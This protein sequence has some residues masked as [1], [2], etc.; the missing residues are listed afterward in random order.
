MNPLTSGECTVSPQCAKS[1]VVDTVNRRILCNI[2]KGSIPDKHSL[3]IYTNGNGCIEI[4]TVKD[5]LSKE[6]LG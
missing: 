2:G 1:M 5:E 4:R 6:K 3:I